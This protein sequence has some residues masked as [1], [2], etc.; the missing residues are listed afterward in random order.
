MTPAETNDWSGADPELRESVRVYQ[1]QRSMRLIAVA[2]TLLA[3]LGT[4]ALY[5]F[6]SYSGH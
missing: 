4:A 2:V 5:A 3:A 6:L 1:H